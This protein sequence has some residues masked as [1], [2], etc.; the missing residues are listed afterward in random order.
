MDLNKSV[1]FGQSLTNTPKAIIDTGSSFLIISSTAYSQFENAMLGVPGVRCSRVLGYCY[2]VS[3]PCS[4]IV[5]S[6][7]PLSFQLDYT[8]FTIP[9]EGYVF[10]EGDSCI[11]AVSSIAD[12]QSLYILGDTFLRNFVVTFDYSNQVM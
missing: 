6:M 1:I 11:V 3:Q 2:T 4:D 10:D 12:S 9:P 8:T 5:S 7:Q